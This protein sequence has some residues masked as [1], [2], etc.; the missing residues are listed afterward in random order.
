MEI[1]TRLARYGFGQ[2]LCDIV[3]L[4]DGPALHD[5]LSAWR[6]DLQWALRADPQKHLP[7]KCSSIAEE[8]TDDFPNPQ[9]VQ[10]Y[11]NP[12]TSDLGSFFRFRP[13]QTPD[14]R[15]IARMLVNLDLFANVHE[16]QRYFKERLWDGLALREL[17][18]QTTAGYNKQRKLVFSASFHFVL[19]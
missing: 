14:V 12:A 11:L 2:R 13:P 16:I 7:R 3:E 6:S 8:I 10:C 15:K 9:I 4:Y 18:D 19:Y 1:A 5:H 17:I